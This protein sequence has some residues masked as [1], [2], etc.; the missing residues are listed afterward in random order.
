MLKHSLRN[1]TIF[2]KIDKSLS[3]WTPTYVSRYMFD[4]QELVKCVKSSSIIHPTPI[5]I[6]RN[7]L[8]IIECPWRRLLCEIGVFVHH[9]QCW[10]SGENRLCSSSDNHLYPLLS[11]ISFSSIFDIINITFLMRLSGHVW[12][13]LLCISWTTGRHPLYET[14]QHVLLLKWT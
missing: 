14:M 3:L 9:I 6:S 12:L 8:Y 10:N 13:Q 11:H 1:R 5:F 4:E 7:G 2:F